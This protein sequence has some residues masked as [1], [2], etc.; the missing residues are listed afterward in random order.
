M[1][2]TFQSLG[3]H[4]KPGSISRNGVRQN[5]CPVSHFN[6][7]YKYPTQMIT[8]KVEIEKNSKATISMR[9]C[10][11]CSSRHVKIKFTILLPDYGFAAHPII[12]MDFDEMT[13]EE[14]ETLMDQIVEDIKEK[15]FDEVYAE[16]VESISELVQ[17]EDIE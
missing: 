6:N 5:G 1:F 4:K 17:E 12:K 11:L 7:Q 15:I 10:R 14:A 16:T 2:L 9:L 13:D 3:A 8:R